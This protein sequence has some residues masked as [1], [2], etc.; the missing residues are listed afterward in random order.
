MTIEIYPS[1]V[2][3]EPAEL[4]EWEGSI[5]GFLDAQGC[6]YNARAEQ[7]IVVT[8]RGV[9]VPSEDWGR[10]HVSATETVQ[11]RI[12]A[13]GFDP[14]SWAYIA[15]AAVMA[16]SLTMGRPS[17]GKMNDT[18]Q[19][20]SLS[21]AEATANRAKLNQAV[22]ELAGRHIRWPDYLTP[23]RRYFADQRTQYLETLLCI[24]PGQYQ[25]GGESVKIGNTPL[26]GLAGAEFHI[27]G[28]G[29]DV[30]VHGMHGNWYNAPEVG[31]TS[32]GTAG[33]E[34]SSDVVSDVQSP[35]GTLTFS[36][37][38]IT[39]ADG[40]SQG[41]GVGTRISLWLLLE[42]TITTI[43]TGTGEE[44]SSISQ[45]VGN[46]ADCE[47]LNTNTFLQMQDGAVELTL[48]VKSVTGSAPNKEV[49]FQEFVGDDETG[50]Y[51]DY[52]TAPGARAVHF[53]RMS[54]S[55]VVG[56]I[57]GGVATVGAVVE[58]FDGHIPDPTWLGFPS[59]SMSAADSQLTVTGG[60][61][62][63]K[64]AGPYVACP[65]GESSQ[66]FE[67]DLFF[68]S[69]L[70]HINDAGDVENQT[71]QVEVQYKPHGSNSWES[72]TKTYTA[73]TLDQI[74]YTER[75]NVAAA[76]RLEFRLRRTSAA[77]T[78]TR[79]N[80]KVQWYG[81]RTLLASPA[82]YPRWTTIAIRIKGLGEIGASSENQVNLIATRILPTLQAS[83]TWGAPQPTR[84]I[85]AFVRHIANSVGYADDQLDTQEFTR[86]HNIWTARG[87]TVDHIFNEG[88]V[89]NAIDTCLAAGMAEL[90]LEDGLLRPVRD[91][92]RTEWEHSYSAQ[93]A[94]EDIR[95]IFTSRKHDDND[96]VQ[97]EY[98]DENDSYTT[99]TVDCMLPGSPGL[100]L[101]K[102][103]LQGVV[104]RTR[105]WRIGMRR[106]REIRYQRWS[107]SFST[108]LDA[109]NSF[110][111]GY[112]AI[113]P[114][115]P[116]YGQS[117]I[118]ERVQGQTLTLSE[119]PIW[120]AG[121]HVIAWRM[122]NGRLAGPFPA[123]KGATDYEVIATVPPGTKMPVVTL[124]QEPPHAYFGTAEQWALPALVRRI[125]PDSGGK[126]KVQAVNYDARV[127]QDDDAAPTS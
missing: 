109:L 84:D 16:Y 11:V 114:D 68:P 77:N 87:E 125:S 67:F 98:I 41:I 70:G 27:Y 10:F 90:S 15:L 48:K 51:V 116:E 46:F 17:L 97:I 111:G 37:Y 112:I 3:A 42:C 80:D 47:P 13:H 38:T 104:D 23:P 14:I 103:K 119:L 63:G 24:G 126:V 1:L 105:A 21:S 55:Y 101:E 95:L 108:E 73:A 85:S 9:E 25:I 7:P 32:A 5:A 118:V 33:L 65:G 113:V 86:L 20:R 78:D 50:S 30:A 96:G 6:A 12:V 93:N 44:V 64:W 34:L 4:H 58:Q 49:T 31:G 99:K 36:G 107:Y 60:N 8:V 124:R 2:A 88:T 102:I 54:R 72:I 75:V 71:V 110:Y 74:G 122:P 92:V 91:G 26:S 76:D 127:Y 43:T 123:A 53:R 94:T 28:P 52:V 45:F 115:V 61:V 22:P 56:S 100:K 40:W 57:A 81:L 66:Q 106:A 89:K 83:G 39:A 79:T 29:A 117:A 121:A 18:P 35:G 69:G 59:V 82:A 120:N 62:Y 19:G